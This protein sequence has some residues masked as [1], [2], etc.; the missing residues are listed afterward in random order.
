MSNIKKIIYAICG[1]CGFIIIAILYSFIDSRVSIKPELNSPEAYGLDSLEYEAEPIMYFTVWQRNE[2]LWSDYPD[3]PEHSPF[4]YEKTELPLKGG[5]TLLSVTNA[6]NI[7]RPPF[8][9]LS[10]TVSYDGPIK[11]QYDILGPELVFFGGNSDMVPAS[12]V[13]QDDFFY[14]AD[15]SFQGDKS[16]SFSVGRFIVQNDEY[17]RE[18]D[19]TPYE[20]YVNN[21][22]SRYG[23]TDTFDREGFFAIQNFLDIYPDAPEIYG[24][25]ERTVTTT[26]LTIQ[27][28]HPRLTDVVVATAVIQ[29]RS[30]SRWDAKDSDK[31]KLTYDEGMAFKEYINKEYSEFTVKSYEQSDSFSWEQ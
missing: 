7:Y 29:I 1:F 30:Y 20:K 26:C 19:H 24:M 16:V 5:N 15:S 12:W 23:T 10:F 6:D 14:N 21:W 17:Y 22:L 11:G 3:I 28:M 8:N 2:R 13:G 27:A 18:T 25:Y 31:D 4:F 9:L